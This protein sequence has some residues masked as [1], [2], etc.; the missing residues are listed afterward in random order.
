[1]ATLGNALALCRVS[2]SASGYAGGK[3]DVGAYDI[4]VLGLFEV[5]TNGRRRREEFFATHQLGDSIIRLYE[6]YAELLPAGPAR[7]RAAA[8]A[9]SVATVLGPLEHWATALAPALEYVDH[10]SIIGLGSTR[11]AAAVLHDVIGS[12]LDLTEGV[13]THVDDIVALRPDAHLLRWT[14]SGI[15][16]SSG[17][18]FERPYLLLSIFGSDGLV[19]RFEQFDVGHEDEALARFD[20]LT[21]EPPAVRR[22]L[23]PN[24]ATATAAC[25]EAAFAARDA[26]ALSALHAG[27]YEMVDRTT[28]VTYDWQGELA[29]LRALM[30]AE[31]ATL[32]GEPLATL[33]DALLLA[34]M[35]TCAKRFAGRKFD[36]GTY[37]VESVHLIEVD[38]QG[39][40]RRVERFAID[41][42]GDGLARLYERYAELLADGPECERAKATARSVAAQVLPLDLDRIASVTAPAV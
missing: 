16:R 4:S 39:R 38:A 25:V 11:G 22:R 32:R 7:A 35:S 40:C 26:D 17:G 42:L 10:R 12:L 36:V 3:L 6:H 20:E 34:R 24:A 31:G 27:E 8:T 30:K 1:L 28:G 41:G 33:G 21:A 5:D 23:R 29:S 15:Q 19:A 37:E 18:V 2:V 9:R 13:A 14:T